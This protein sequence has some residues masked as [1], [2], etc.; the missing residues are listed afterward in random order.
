MIFPP[1]FSIAKLLF[2]YI[3][4]DSLP[5]VDELAIRERRLQKRRDSDEDSANEISAELSCATSRTN[6]SQ[7]IDDDGK[8]DVGGSRMGIGMPR[9]RE[10]DQLAGL[11]SVKSLEGTAETF[12]EAGTRRFRPASQERILKAR[13][14]D[15]LT[16]FIWSR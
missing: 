4:S 5:T 16:S 14:A 11:T 8:G 3:S 9:G 15:V 13:L 2:K 1:K 10:A 7:S 6:M 12:R